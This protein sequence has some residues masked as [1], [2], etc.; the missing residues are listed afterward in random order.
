[1]AAFLL[2]DAHAFGVVAIGAEGAGAGG[3]DPLAA[4]LMAALLFG[5]PLAQRFHQLVEP[6][7]RLDRGLFLGAQVLFGQLFQ[8]FGAAGPRLQHRLGGDFLQPLEAFGKGAVETVKVAFVLDHRGAGQMVE[9]G[10][11]HR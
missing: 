2:A 1:V 9:P 3:A 8:P 4:A 5:Q 6:A 10:R 11:R 7:Q